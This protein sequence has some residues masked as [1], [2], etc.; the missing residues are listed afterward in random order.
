MG[1]DYHIPDGYQERQRAWINDELR[2]DL[3]ERIDHRNFLMGFG[4]DVAKAIEVTNANLQLD[5]NDVIL[6]KNLSDRGGRHRPGD[7]EGVGEEGG[8]SREVEECR[9]KG[10]GEKSQHG[11]V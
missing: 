3:I 9:S 11:L 6:D 4:H 8:D 1:R 2:T 10:E 7:N 5:A